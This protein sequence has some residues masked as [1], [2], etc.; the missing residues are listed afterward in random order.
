MAKARKIRKPPKPDYGTLRDAILRGMR[1]WGA[2]TWPADLIRAI[3]AEVQAW[4]EQ[5]RNK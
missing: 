1:R 2:R 4:I 5:T 3:E